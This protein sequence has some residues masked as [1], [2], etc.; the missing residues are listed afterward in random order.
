[1]SVRIVGKD[2]ASKPCGQYRW[3]RCYKLVTVL[4][5]AELA[6]RTTAHMTQYFGFHFFFIGNAN[7]LVT[8]G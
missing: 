1:M 8:V 6:N 5:M 7:C 3:W 4:M 2:T